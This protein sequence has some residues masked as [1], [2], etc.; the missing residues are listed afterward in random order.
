MKKMFEKRAIGLYYY[1][2]EEIKEGDIIDYVGS[3]CVIEYF[4]PY[5][6]F[7]LRNGN[8]LYMINDA[9]RGVYKKLGTIY[10]NPEL[11]K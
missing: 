5:A 8:E 9:P 1:N 4:A 10:E 3:K 7:V 2:G 11:L 6:S